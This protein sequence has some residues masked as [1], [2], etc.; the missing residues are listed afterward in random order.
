M[1][2][3]SLPS[4][5]M[6]KMH[7]SLCQNFRPDFLCM[8][9]I[10]S[11]PPY[12]FSYFFLSSWRCPCTSLPG[13]AAWHKWWASLLITLQLWLRAACIVRGTNEGSNLPRRP[14]VQPWLPVAGVLFQPWIDSIHGVFSSCATKGRRQWSLVVNNCLTWKILPG[15]KLKVLF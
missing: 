9:H 8:F 7:C 11:V 3:E 10:F 14:C 5:L 1:L 12:L 2:K 15:S 13:I 6:V 4:F